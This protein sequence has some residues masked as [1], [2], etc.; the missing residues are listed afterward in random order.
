MSVVEK[1]HYVVRGMKIPFSEV[2]G[3]YLILVTES[4]EKPPMP[5]DFKDKAV[6]GLTTLKSESLSPNLSDSISFGLTTLKSESLSPNLSD[7]VSFGLTAKE[8]EDL[9]SNLSE[10]VTI[11]NV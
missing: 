11:T 7:S 5:F 10:S 2:A 4:T 9:Q 1:G 6:F 3:K 8:S